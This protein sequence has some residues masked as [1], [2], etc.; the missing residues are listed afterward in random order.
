MPKKQRRPHYPRPST[1]PHPSLSLSRSTF[2]PHGS[3]ASQDDCSVTES[4]MNLRNEEARR[5]PSRPPPAATMHPDLKQLLDVPETPRPRPGMRTAI[6][7]PIPRMPGPPPPPS[8][9]LLRSRH[10]PDIAETD[11]SGI[12]RSSVQLVAHEQISLPGAKCPS[13]GSLLHISLKAMAEQWDWHLQY[14]H[15]CLASIPLHLR[16]TLLTYVAR[17]AADE[18]LDRSYSTLRILFPNGKDSGPDNG[19]VQD[20]LEGNSEVTRLDL[21]RALGSWL[22][23][24]SSLKKE[25]L[26]PQSPQS[27]ANSGAGAVPESRRPAEPPESWE[28]AEHAPNDLAKQVSLLESPQIS[29]TLRYSTLLHLS[30]AL[31]PSTASAVSVASWSSL[32][33]IAPHLSTL[34]SLSL[35]FWPRPTLTPH[36]ASVSARISNPVSRTLPR[37]PYGGTDMYTEF[38]SSWREAAGILRRLSRHL[39]CLR[40]LDL[41]GCGPWFGAL[42]WTDI[43]KS[44]DGLVPGA[45]HPETGPDWNGSWRNIEH[46]V[47]GVGWAPPTREDVETSSLALR[48]PSGDQG[49]TSNLKTWPNFRLGSSVEIAGVPKSMSGQGLL[50]WDM[51][52]ERKN[53]LAKKELDKFKAIQARACEVASRLRILRGRAKGKWIKIDCL[54]RQEF[55]D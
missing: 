30:L 19:A 36:A 44:D 6:A 37:I 47:L 7:S 27:F 42:I 22:P 35:A 40:W 4:L 43:E 15:H 26:L 16:E 18:S 9:Q 49:S 25:L 5:L 48:A 2:A 1:N 14:D 46:L 28:D 17:Y 52:E 33:A 54:A 24:T 3:S 20:F 34:E 21:G 55:P 29:P 38:E 23:R 10:A 11:A 13:R 8:W 32:L 51:Q 39:Y 31:S 45:R 41:T 50:S 53:Y 12:S